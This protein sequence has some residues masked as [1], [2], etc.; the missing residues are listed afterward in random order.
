MVGEISRIISRLNTPQNI[1]ERGVELRT[2]LCED[3]TVEEVKREARKFIL[4]NFNKWKE[5]CLTRNEKIKPKKK[6]E[7]ENIQC[8][9][10]EEEEIYQYEKKEEDLDNLIEELSKYSHKEITI[11]FFKNYYK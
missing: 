11:E 7:E 3:N 1:K 4:E 5:P 10:I 8:N 2:L 6:K 9:Q